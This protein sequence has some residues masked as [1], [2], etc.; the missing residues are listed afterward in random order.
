MDGRR[1]QPFGFFTC[2]QLT[3]KRNKNRSNIKR[4][5]REGIISLITRKRSWGNVA[6]KGFA[7]I[8]LA[9]VEK[10]KKGKLAHC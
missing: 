10:K 8:E 6:F 3:R 7:A 9:C 2:V 5:V 4:E 1:N